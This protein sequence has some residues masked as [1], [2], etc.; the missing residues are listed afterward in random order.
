MRTTEDMDLI[1]PVSPLIAPISIVVPSMILPRWS[2][3]ITV[4][5]T[6]WYRGIKVDDTPRRRQRYIH[7]RDTRKYSKV[8]KAYRPSCSFARIP[9]MSYLCSVVASDIFIV[10]DTCTTGVMAGR[11]YWD[12]VW[13]YRCNTPRVVPVADATYGACVV[14]CRSRSPPI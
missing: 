11:T 3:M 10:N 14:S 4:K 2:L 8:G 1:I 12:I 6:W 9:H 13:K 7:N 5:I